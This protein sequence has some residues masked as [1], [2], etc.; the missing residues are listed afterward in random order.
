MDLEEKIDGVEE[1]L[2][3]VYKASEPCQRIAAGEGIGP[4]TATALVAA[5]SVRWAD[6]APEAARAPDSHGSGVFAVAPR[7]LS[8]R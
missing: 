1:Q 4:V 6:S 2:Q 8:S 3:T 5:M 7:T